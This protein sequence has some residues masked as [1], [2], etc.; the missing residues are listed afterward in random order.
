MYSD[1]TLMVALT[2]LADVYDATGELAKFAEVRKR[3]MDVAASKGNEEKS[4][5]FGLEAAHAYGRA[6]KYAESRAIFL[7]ALQW[8]LPPA[9]RLAALD[10]LLRFHH[11]CLLENLSVEELQKLSLA[12]LCAW[13]ETPEELIKETFLLR[14]TVSEVAIAQVVGKSSIQDLQKICQ[15]MLQASH[16]EAT[17][18]L[19]H[20]VLL[21][22]ALDF[23]ESNQ[24]QIIPTA[25]IVSVANKQDDLYGEVWRAWA[26]AAKQL[27]SCNYRGEARVC[28]DRALLKL[29][30][31]REIFDKKQHLTA[32]NQKPASKQRKVISFSSVAAA[33]VESPTGTPQS[34]K[35]DLEKQKSAVLSLLT[36][37]S[38]NV[39]LQRASMLTRWFVKGSKGRALEARAAARAAQE[40]IRSICAVEDNSKSCFAKS[41][42]MWRPAL[43][44]LQLEAASYLIPSEGNRLAK[45]AL[46]EINQLF[47]PENPK[48]I[49][50]GPQNTGAESKARSDIAKDPLIAHALNVY[51]FFSA[52]LE[53]SRQDSSGQPS[54]SDEVLR[55][56]A[57]LQAVFALNNNRVSEALEEL[58][59]VC[60]PPLTPSGSSD[61]VSQ[62]DLADRSPSST[63]VLP[64]HLSLQGEALF[65]H[66]DVANS[67]KFLL[68]AA[69]LDPELSSTFLYLGKIYAQKGDAE[70]ALKC[71]EKS[72]DLD[73]MQSGLLQIVAARHWEAKRPQQIIDLYK[74]TIAFVDDLAHKGSDVQTFQETYADAWIR[75]GRLA[76][77]SNNY[78]EA[79]KC[80]QRAVA[81]AESRFDAWQ[82]LGDAYSR[83]GKREG[84]LMALA[85]AVECMNDQVQADQ[86]AYV[87]LRLGRLRLQNTDYLGAL[88]ALEKSS[89]LFP[90]EATSWTLAQARVQFAES[91][92]SSGRFESAADEVERGI[93]DLD[94]HGIHPL[95]AFSQ[96]RARL[97]AIRANALPAAKAKDPQGEEAYK[98][99]MRNHAKSVF[100]EP[101]KSQAWLT[102]ATCTIR[103]TQQEI[104]HAQRDTELSSLVDDFETYVTQSRRCAEVSIA[105]QPTDANAWSMLGI[106]HSLRITWD[107]AAVHL[108]QHCLVR[109]TQ[110]DPSGASAAWCNLGIL[111]ERC[112]RQEAALRAFTEAQAGRAHEKAVSWTARARIAVG[113][114]D[115]NDTKVLA[116][117]RCAID[118]VT[119]GSSITSDHVALSEYAHQNTKLRWEYLGRHGW[120]DIEDVARRVLRRCPNDRMAHYYM[121]IALI[122]RSAH[123]ATI[124]DH[125]HQSPSEMAYH[126]LVALGDIEVDKFPSNLA[127]FSLATPHEMAMALLLAGKRDLE[128]PE[129]VMADP[130]VAYLKNGSKLP[131]LQE[132]GEAGNKIARASLEI[133][134]S[135]DVNISSVSSA[136]LRSQILTAQKRS[137]EA[138]YS[139]P[140]EMA[141]WISRARCSLQQDELVQVR[142][143]KEYRSDRKSMTRC[144]DVAQT[145]HFARRDLNFYQGAL[146]RSL[147]YMQ[148]AFHHAAQA[149]YAAPYNRETARLFIGSVSTPSQAAAALKLARRLAEAPDR[150]LLDL[151]R[152]AEVAAMAGDEIISEEAASLLSNTASGTDKEQQDLRGLA[153]CLLGRVKRAPPLYLEGLQELR[154]APL[155]WIEL[156][157]LIGNTDPE[158]A[159]ECFVCAVD[160]FTDDD[161]GTK[162]EIECYARLAQAEFLASKFGV[163]R[164][165]GG[166]NK[167][168]KAFPEDYRVHLVRGC[169]SML[170][171]SDNKSRKAA[172][173]SLRKSLDLHPD[174]VFAQELFDSLQ[175]ED[176]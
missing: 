167:V 25:T 58:K 164:C 162:S 20:S 90:S 139:A 68:K 31:A 126:H 149:Y 119:P 55:A 127:D 17:C 107:S 86:Q 103:R 131:S 172:L 65:K 140:W 52:G 82:G 105:L 48:T 80:F 133:N 161:E 49:K 30:T 166:M 75:L 44:A 170:Q 113:E 143:R 116:T 91:L 163:G 50:V 171:G 96:L 148:K 141:G 117:L 39:W 174:N 22:I 130:V 136:H 124:L 98:C 121:A 102:V 14:K 3:Q 104:L 29:R 57:A 169:V 77:Y 175:N 2:R 35:E 101:W 129:E 4:Q 100:F 40:G 71:F 26:L 53:P 66:G 45:E 32:S 13:E 146:Q 152:F 128:F 15:S 37:E 38:P 145:L 135:D 23:G 24:A 84:A 43:A 156:G 92:L 64:W 70:R 168:A 10:V 137:P 21:T 5:E 28:C 42:A 144:L 76:L 134:H 11:D 173:A 54:V 123:R 94:R 159:S 99:A 83:T 88:A 150:T 62:L 97:N 110:L 1:S 112:G 120:S 12:Y 138:I 69:Q 132:A 165:L 108:A 153:K 154:D 7:Q 46:V 85:K 109:A 158:L 151:V 72:L 19:S 27:A 114:K 157:Y 74:R 81:G 51:N 118:A 56:M 160:F 16:D 155:I 8:Q 18:A 41:I 87:Y 142:I 63:T 147:G 73:P 106:S 33:S 59:V 89:E 60:R 93:S 61:L 47:E 67:T 79:E 34:R 36:K 122:A 176:K 115:E 78:V 6:K 111:F 95:L 9:D 125:L